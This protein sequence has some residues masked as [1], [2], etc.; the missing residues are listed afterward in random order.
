MLGC[1]NRRYHDD[2]WQAVTDYCDI[3]KSLGLEISCWCENGGYKDYDK[4]DNMPRSKEY[5]FEILSSDGVKIGG[6]MKMMACGTV[7]D[8]FSK[9]DTTFVMY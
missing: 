4:Q 5:K 1:G 9:Y 2:H 6:Y 3:V 8:P 7:D